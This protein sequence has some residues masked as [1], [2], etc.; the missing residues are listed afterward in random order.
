MEN[1]QEVKSYQLHILFEES[2]AISQN[3]S[4]IQNRITQGKHCLRLF[5]F[6]TLQDEAWIKPTLADA[7]LMGKPQDPD[8]RGGTIYDN[9]ILHHAD[10]FDSCR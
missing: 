1:A 5:L 9:K 4:T 2:A 6:L 7:T 8:F 3:L 10:L